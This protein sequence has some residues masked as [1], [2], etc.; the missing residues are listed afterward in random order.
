[1]PIPSPSMCPGCGM[2]YR[3]LK[4]GFTFADIVSMLWVDDPDPARWRS[5]RRNSIL[6]FWHEIKLNLWREH[7]DLCSTQLGDESAQSSAQAIAY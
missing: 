5:K 3:D 4:T 2:K 1:M 6:G 7:C